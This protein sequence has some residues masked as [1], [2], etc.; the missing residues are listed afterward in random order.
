MDKSYTRVQNNTR[1]QTMSCQVSHTLQNHIP[2]VIARVGVIVTHT[3]LGLTHAYFDN[4]TLGD[5]SYAR[6]SSVTH[7]PLTFIVTYSFTATWFAGPIQTRRMDTSETQQ[8]H[9]PHDLAELYAGNLLCHSDLCF[10]LLLLLISAASCE[11]RHMTCSTIT[12]AA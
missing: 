1:T 9:R 5:K 4:N 3:Q 2:L 10:G 7:S 11:G 6:D 12:R 8:T